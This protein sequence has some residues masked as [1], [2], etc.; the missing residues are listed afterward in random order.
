MSLV[1]GIYLLRPGTAFPA[2]WANYLLGN[3]K[4]EAHVA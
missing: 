4:R 3:R 2:G 1:R